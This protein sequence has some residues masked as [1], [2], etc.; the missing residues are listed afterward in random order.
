MLWGFS[1]PLKL[2][3]PVPDQPVKYQ[4]LSGSAVIATCV[5]PG[6]Q[7]VEG[8]STLPPGSATIVSE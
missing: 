1:I 7:R 8:G 6:S 4:P 3:G 5:F 2:P